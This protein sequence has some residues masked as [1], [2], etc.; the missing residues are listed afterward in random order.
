ML[1]D[2]ADVTMPEGLVAVDSEEEQ[3]DDEFESIDSTA[4]IN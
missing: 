4:W 2:D 3:S 1:Q